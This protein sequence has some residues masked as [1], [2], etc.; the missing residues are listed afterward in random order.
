MN[1]QKGPLK[2]PPP[3]LAIAVR[4]LASP[5]QRK[6]EKKSAKALQPLLLLNNATAGGCFLV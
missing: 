3:P 5:F 1:T 2:P 4:S 6:F